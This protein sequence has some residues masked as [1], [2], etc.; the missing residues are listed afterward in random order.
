MLAPVAVSALAAATI[1]LFTASKSI[2]PL[3]AV[4]VGMWTKA[5]IPALSELAQ[6]AEEA[7]PI[8]KADR[9]MAGQSDL[10]D[11]ASLAAL[12]YEIP[13]AGPGKLLNELHTAESR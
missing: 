3:A 12:V 2:R 10:W 7:E 9:P 13:P 6:E 4:P 8:G 1:L 11:W 5:S